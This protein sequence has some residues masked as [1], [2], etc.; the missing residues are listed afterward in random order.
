MSEAK[1]AAAAPKRVESDVYDRQIRL[2]GADAQRK[3]SSARV[4]YVH[5]TGV[6]SEILKNLVLAGIRAAICDGRPY[7]SAVAS[8]PSS[9]LP[10]ADRSGGDNENVVTANG[11]NS[12]PPA[13]KARPATVASAM[14]PHV[15]ELN[16]LL[17]GCEINESLIEDV[18]DEYFAKFDIVVASHIGMEQAR[19]IAKATVASGNKFILVDTFGLEGCAMLDLGPDHQFRKELGKDKLSDVMKNEPYVSFADMLDVPLADATARWDKVP[20]KVY[21]KYRSY[22]EYHAKSGTW[23]GEDN[24]SDYVEQTKKWLAD[25]KIVS[26]DYLGDDDTLN[27]TASVATCEV[28]PVCAVLGGMIGN[29]VIKAISGKADPA[30]NILMFD[31]ADGGCRIF[32]LKK[33]A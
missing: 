27:H 3:M 12:D 19:R 4:L 6:S 14:H 2:W 25:S 13:K 26:E 17:D 33:K 20:P 24:A 18:P 16:P 31:G 8:M 5:I 21:T 15:V 29:E 9:F 1:E 11:D 7:P 23:P 28:S 30:N 22:L 32:L 10:P